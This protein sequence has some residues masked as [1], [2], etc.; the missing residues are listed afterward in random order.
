MEAF[1]EWESEAIERLRTWLVESKHRIFRS[2]QTVP[3][4]ESK[5]DADDL[6]DAMDAATS[7]HAHSLLLELRARERSLLGKIE[8]ALRRIANGSFATCDRCGQ[9]IAPNRLAALPVTTLCIDCQEEE[10]IELR[11]IS[12][13]A[14]RTV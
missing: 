10:E 11:R 9:E 1:S 13:E 8:A 5:I 12:L 3:G 14:R 6:P 2:V 7:E 4:D